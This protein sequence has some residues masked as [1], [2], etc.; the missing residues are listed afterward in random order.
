MPHKKMTTKL[1]VKILEE[2]HFYQSAAHV[3]KL[4]KHSRILEALYAAGVANWEGY[5]HAISIK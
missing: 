4:D 1:V 5:E 2:N 3:E